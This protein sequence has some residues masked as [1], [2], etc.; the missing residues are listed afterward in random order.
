MSEELKGGIEA[1]ESTESVEQDIDPELHDDRELA[2][3]EDDV[4]ELPDYDPTQFEFPDDEYVP[5]GDE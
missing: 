5:E 4:I 3:T 1:G 2:E